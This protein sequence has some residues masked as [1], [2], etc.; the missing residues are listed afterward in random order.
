MSNYETFS[1]FERVYL[2]D[3]FVTSLRY[4]DEALRFELE[5]VLR[6]GHELYSCPKQGE[7][8]C[9]RRAAIVFF[10][11][12]DVVWRKLF[13]FP[14]VDGDRKIDFGNIDSLQRISGV[15]FVSGD[16]GEVEFGCDK[17]ELSI[18]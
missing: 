4:D 10:K 17:V 6:E 1:G 8:Y 16:W 2:E 12:F 18:E 5:L 11:P 15:Y 7:Q 3:S 13:V 14:Y 9:Y